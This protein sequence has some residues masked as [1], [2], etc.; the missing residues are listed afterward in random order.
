M[1]R[2]QVTFATNSE[3]NVTEVLQLRAAAG[4]TDGTEESWSACIDQALA[5]FTAR[6]SDDAKLVGVAFLVGNQR[7]MQL[8]DMVVQPSHRQSGIG[9]AL[10]RS[11]KAHADALNVK[12]YGLTWDQASP[13][14]HGFYESEGFRD[15]TFAMWHQDSLPPTPI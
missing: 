7:H 4:W 9:R 1:T 3:I 8:V 10:V 11:A 12:Y 5:T 15:V 14:L 6:N 2:N 13:W